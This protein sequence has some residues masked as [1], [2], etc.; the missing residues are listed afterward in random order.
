MNSVPLFHIYTQCLL[1]V[2]PD[3]LNIYISEKVNYKVANVQVGLFVIR[4]D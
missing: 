3:H 4:S 2:L 1:F